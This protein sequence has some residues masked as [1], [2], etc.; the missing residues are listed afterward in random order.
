[1][2]NI[3]VLFSLISISSWA[4]IDGAYESP[5]EVIDPPVNDIANF[6]N[7]PVRSN[8]EEVLQIV[9]PARSQG[10][11]GTCTMFSAIGMM[12]SILIRLGKADQSIDLSEEWMEY[13]IMTKKQ[14]EGSSTSKNIRAL[15]NSGYIKESSWPYFRK[16]WSDLTTF[17]EAL[18]FCGHL[19]NLPGALASCLLGHRDP[20]YLSMDEADLREKDSKF[21][22][23][24]KEAFSN[25][26]LNVVPNIK[27]KKSYKIKKVS[28]IKNLLNEGTPLIMGTK[29]Y[30]GSWNHSKTKKLNIQK[31]DKSK[32]YKGIVTYPEPGSVDRKISFEQG[33]G[34]SIILIGFDDEKVVKSK[35]LMEDGSWKEFTYQGVYYF[36]NSWGWKSYGRDFEINGKPIPGYGM[37]TQKYAHEMGSFFHVPLIK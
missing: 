12:E 32:W 33:G 20:S 15:L 28:A 11:R 29:L 13:V 14:T 37:I 5:L 21:L 19:K 22:I 9:T 3:I 27:F 26:D 4:D 25:R 35:M 34:H 24:R 7:L 36:K 2:L 30:Y 6:K 1:M 23:F 10:G 17:P 31:R 8:V 16:K 18:E